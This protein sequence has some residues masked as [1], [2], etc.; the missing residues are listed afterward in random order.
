MLFFCKTITKCLR[1][2]RIKSFLL[3]EKIL[4]V[5]KVCFNEQP[6]IKTNFSLILSPIVFSHYGVLNNLIRSISIRLKN[7]KQ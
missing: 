2:D 4:Y 3:L 6:M 5:I 7:L 1:L